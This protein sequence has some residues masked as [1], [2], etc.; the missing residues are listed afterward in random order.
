MIPPT[1]P[2]SLLWAF[3]LRRQQMNV[4]VRIDALEAAVRQRYDDADL[5]SMVEEV[6]EEVRE[7]AKRIEAVEANVDALKKGGQGLTVEDDGEEQQAE[8]SGIEDLGTG[9]LRPFIVST[10]GHAGECD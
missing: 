10:F 4:A 8:G 6:R 1:S 7:L 5:R 3:Q 9:A 2:T